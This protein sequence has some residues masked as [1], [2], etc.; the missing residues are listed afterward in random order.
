MIGG[1]KLWN[2]YR[3]TRGRNA[4]LEQTQTYSIDNP[5][6]E[7]V[8]CRKVRREPYNRM[9]VKTKK[10][11]RPLVEEFLLILPIDYEVQEDDIAEE[12]DTGKFY[13]IMGAEDVS[14]KGQTYQCPI[15]RAPDISK[16]AT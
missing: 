2:I 7:D 6:Y 14:R 11:S 3:P 12:Q 10:S 1:N 16:E 5:L 8:W 4:I 9:E 15:T 13:V